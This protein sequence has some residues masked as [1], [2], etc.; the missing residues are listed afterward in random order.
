MN[1]PEKEAPQKDVSG[2]MMQPPPTTMAPMMMAPMQPIG[3]SMPVY[4]QPQ[5]M[6]PPYTY[7]GMQPPMGSPFGQPYPYGQPQPPMG[8]LTMG[9]A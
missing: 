6:Q 4:M 2:Y 9:V 3:S 1:S 8:S 5:E 7:S